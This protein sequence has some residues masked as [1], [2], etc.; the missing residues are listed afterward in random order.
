[1]HEA[2]GLKRDYNTLTLSD[3]KFPRDQ[4]FAQ[5]FVALLQNQ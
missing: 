1:M 4:A 2:M 3:T 5:N